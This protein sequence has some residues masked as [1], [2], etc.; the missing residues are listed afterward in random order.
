MEPESSISG[1]VLGHRDFV[2]TS[3]PGDKAYALVRD[4]TFAKS[5][6]PFQEDEV[7]IHSRYERQ[8]RQTLGRGERVSLEFTG[9]HDGRRGGR[10]PVGGVE[11]E[12]Q[13]AA[14]GAS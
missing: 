1:T 10:C 8:Q 6:T 9:R 3:C 7:P 5:P 11:S 14:L 12:G 2:A 4:G 13:P